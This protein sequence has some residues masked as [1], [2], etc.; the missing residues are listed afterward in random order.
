M[1]TPPA[2][3]PSGRPA[4]PAL[5]PPSGGAAPVRQPPR[6]PGMAGA[7]IIFG[8]L[9]WALGIAAERAP[10]PEPQPEPLVHVVGQVRVWG[11]VVGQRLIGAGLIVVVLGVSWRIVRSRRRQLQSHVL[12]T[13]AAVLH[14]PAG[15]LKMSGA[16]WGRRGAGLRSGRITYRPA[17]GVIADFSDQLTAALTP[18]T[19][20]AITIRWQP[21]RRRFL[22]APKVAAAPRLEERFPQLGK[23]ADTL[24]HIVGAIAVDQ[25]RSVVAE[26]G[27]VQRLVARYG[28]T[29]RD[30]GDGFRQ[31]VQ[32]VLDA[33]SPSPTGYWT[34]RWDPASN[35]VTIEPA[36]PLPRK[37]AFPLRL[38]TAADQMQIP[39]GLGDGGTLV[40]WQPEV[41]P[42]LLVVGPT[43]SGKTIFLN[44]LVIAC[45]ARGW[46]VILV[47]PKELSFRGFDPQALEHRGWPVW[48]GIETVAT[49]EPDMENAIDVAY[50]TMRDRYA[51][52]KTF[53][54]READLAPLLL[55]VDEAG[56]LVE[57]LTEY[58]T[59]QE[60]VRDLERKATLAGDDGDDIAKPKGTKNPELRKIWSSLR[61]G[62]QGRT[63][64]VTATQRPD[65]SFI[66]GE[67]RSNLTTR[68]GLGHL[69]G[70][71]LEMVFNTRSV[72][73]RVHEYVVDPRTGERQRIRVRGRAT[74]DVGSGP[75]TIQT[76]WV[77]DPA[78]RI[79][80]ELTAEDNQLVEQMQ[81]M[82]NTSAARWAG[83]QVEAPPPP[84]DAAA[85]LD[86]EFA[87]AGEPPPFHELSAPDL[88]EDMHTEPARDLQPGHVVM[89][90]VDCVATLAQIEEIDD[91]PDATDELEISYRVCDG[92][93][94][95]GQLGVTTL[96]RDER[97]RVSELGHS[98]RW[99][100]ATGHP[101]K[102]EAVSAPATNEPTEDLE[103]LLLAVEIV[104]QAQ[105][106]STA[107]LQRKLR[108]S[109]ARAGRLLDEMELWGVVGPFAGGR[110]RQVLVEPEQLDLQLSQMKQRR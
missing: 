72:Q 57:R 108:I 110:V 85:E 22:V 49:T 8:V 34:V 61:L 55:V 78:K 95:D 45:A 93:D 80:G 17:E 11:P 60:K 106:G 26:D 88:F 9:G 19:A 50:T 67:A 83:R 15:Q 21:R 99:T 62:R 74:V 41:M 90:E 27:S 30:I 52:L 20:T 107:I 10:L 86:M 24:A 4:V 79:T 89:L 18:H 56:E 91:D 5:R 54:V 73:Q 40:S 102:P 103:L 42:H 46:I 16:R 87:A 32:A 47:D 63:F 109:F 84:A 2:A 28:Q 69:D 100:A 36:Q 64:V 70:A 65:V 92:G 6:W 29:T 48:A 14:L 33:K 71:A 3:R 97:V 35:E 37:A 96:A 104:V 76:F 12:M 81:T 51:A 39:L 25:R 43:G 59:S 66:P 105:L 68:V 77:P 13:C 94:R 38:P 23:V 75:Q 53:E 44:N 31:R 82:V 101:V 1:S 58:H 98:H 7:L